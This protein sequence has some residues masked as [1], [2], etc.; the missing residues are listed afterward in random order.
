MPPP[1]PAPLSLRLAGSTTAEPLLAALIDGFASEYAHVS[2]SVQW[3]NATFVLRQVES[4]AADLGMVTG[5]PPQSVWAAPVALDGIAIVVHPTN[6]LPGLSLSQAQSLFRGRFWHW[7]D[8]GAW[9]AEDEIA[10]L[11]R[12]EG[13]GLRASFEALV[14]EEEPVAPTARVMFDGA[15]VVEWVAASPGAVGYVSHGRVAGEGGEHPVKEVPVEGVL[16]TADSIADMQ[17]RLL[18]PFYLA[19]IQEPEGAARLFVDFCLSREGQAVV[20]QRYVP[21]RGKE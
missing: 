1:D 18:L 5:T 12:E 17:Y 9:A 20:G 21:V 16:P 6:S 7:R 13:S 4:G 10:V 11:S 2:V 19:A 14:M 15:E 3:G 8:F